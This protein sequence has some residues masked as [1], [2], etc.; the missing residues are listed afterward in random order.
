MRSIPVDVSVFQAWMVVG[1]PEPKLMNAETGEVRKD[2][3]SGETIWTV[4]IVAM[5]GRDSTVEQ[6]TVVGEPRGLDVGMPVRVVGLEGTAWAMEGR[7][8]I[9]FRAEQIVPVGDGRRTAPAGSGAGSGAGQ[10][11]GSGT[12]PRSAGTGPVTSPVAG[13]GA[14]RTGGDA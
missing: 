2:R 9:S 14:S 4:P 12:G 8:G 3:A 11:A 6:V 5:R 1:T 10:A 7:S 13:S